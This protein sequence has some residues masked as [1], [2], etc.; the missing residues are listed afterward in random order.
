[1][2]LADKP[3]AAGSSSEAIPP[4]LGAPRKNTYGQILKSSAVIGGSSVLNAGIG[5]VRNKAMAVFLGP[6]GFGL[7]GVYSSIADL[8]RTLAGMGINSSG[9]RQI[10]EAV[11]TGDN[12]RIARTVS[13]LRRVAFLLGALGALLLVLFCQPI[14]RLSFRDYQH[15][16]AVALLSLAVFFGAVSAGQIAV[17]QGMRRI[18]DLA[19]AN[20]LGALYG[21]LLSIGIVYLYWRG[22]DGKRGIVP[23]LVCI[24]AMSVVTTWWYS[25]KVKLQ[26]VAMRLADISG[27]VS[28]LL[29]MG[30]VF[31]ASALMTMGVY[32]LVRIIVLRKMGE[33]A[34]GFYQSAYG[35]SAQYV[36][37]IL[38]AMGADFY[39]RLTAAANDNV[40][41]NRLVNEQAEVGLLLAGPGILATLTFAPFVMLIFYTA[42]FGPA[43]E[44]L[45]WICLGM[46]LRVASW[47][48]AFILLAK[49]ARYPFF[50]SELA[51][52][53]VQVGLVWACV[54]QFGLK[55]TGIA[56][57]GSYVFYWCMIYVIVRSVSGFRWSPENK[58]LG[59]LDVA[60]VT[61]LFAGWYVLPHWIVFAGGAV[62]TLLSGIHSLRRLC[63]L[64]PL[65][66]FPQPVQ[67]LLMFLRLASA[68]ADR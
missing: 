60:L 25:R 12:A 31:M 17:L 39:P 32:Y 45:R 50:W 30:F 47:P 6:A 9:V 59:L 11:G 55:G 64:V 21:M 2:S 29:K 43:V 53:V 15:A 61:A 16:G 48:M 42:K 52:S 46:M 4:E 1:M 24:A 49:G 37:F 5:M 62:A 51:A 63:R 66:R 22:G 54:L 33:D 57:F 41:C 14:S 27:E 23:A 3:V 34:A 26:R 19:R 13:T 68:N 18:A 7:L 10:A 20:V 40:E 44:I 38:Q 58:R 67:R 35:F 56:F 65:G 36:G 28:L 8:A